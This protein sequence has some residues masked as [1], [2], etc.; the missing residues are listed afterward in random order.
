MQLS[1]IE[2]HYGGSQ[3]LVLSF[4]ADRFRSFHPGPAALDDFRSAARSA[5]IEPHD[6]PPLSA[7]CIPDDRVAIVLDR[8]L[9]QAPTLLAEVVSALTSAGLPPEH[10]TVLQAAP[11][12]G[13]TP[14]DPRAEM[15][16]DQRAAVAWKV[17]QPADADQAGYLASSVSGERIYLARELLDADVVLP[18]FTAGFDSVLGYRNSGNLIYPVLSNPA[19]QEKFRG[20]GHRELL[21][22]DDR[23]LRQLGEEICWLLGIQFS[24]AVVPGRAS[25]SAAAIFGGQWEAVQ[26]DARRFINHAWTVS[27]PQRAETVVVSV[28]GAAEVA[29]WEDVGNALSVARDLVTREGRIIVLSSIDAPLGPGLE[30]LRSSR[31]AKAALQQLRKTSPDDLVAATQVASAVEWANVS[32]LSRLDDAIVEE[33]LMSPLNAPIEA[34]RLIALTDDVVL[35]NAAERVR[36]EILPE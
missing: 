16:D 24:V 3:P 34:E 12:P 36:G 4:D 30:L 32:L 18:I 29:G 26:R 10:L 20:E 28:S 17:H 31:S 22:D 9:P 21:P 6:F 13:Q 11:P 5:L 25:G 35:I 7:V 27:L 33:L 2:F 8:S 15:P 19:A 23:P 14:A 1:D